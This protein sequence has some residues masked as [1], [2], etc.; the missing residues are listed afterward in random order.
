[1]PFING[2]F[3]MN[4]AYGRAIERARRAGGIWSE[5]LPEFARAPL[6][7]QNFSNEVSSS[8]GQQ[9]SSGEHWVTIDGRH[10]LIQGTPA[11]RARMIQPKSEKAKK[12]DTSRLWYSMKRVA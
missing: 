8:G 9:Q 12:R 10:V 4:S 11:E 6:Q 5:E 3:Y 1:M 7:E 2:R